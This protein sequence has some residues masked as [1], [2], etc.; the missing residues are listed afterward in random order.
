VAFAALR[1]RFALRAHSIAIARACAARKLDRG[2]ECIPAGLTD[3]AV[4]DAPFARELGN[5]RKQG[6]IAAAWAMR[7]LQTDFGVGLE[8]EVMIRH[9]V[10]LIVHF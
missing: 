6:R 8:S 2:L 10:L 4:P 3:P 1:A 5:V 7:P 9:D